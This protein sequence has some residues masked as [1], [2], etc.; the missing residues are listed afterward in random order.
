MSYIQTKIPTI[1][2]WQIRSI[3]SSSRLLLASAVLVILSSGCSVSASIAEREVGSDEKV[4]ATTEEKIRSVNV[5]FYD[6]NYFARKHGVE[7]W[8]S[9]A[10]GHLFDQ[11]KDLG[12]NRVF[13]RVSIM[14]LEAYPSKVR[15]TFPGPGGGVEPL[16]LLEGQQKLAD[17]LAEGFNPLEAA[18]EHGKRTGI[19]VYAWATLYDE[20]GHVENGNF[21]SQF[22]L[23]N[24]QYQWTSR[25]GERYFK[26]VLSYNFPEVRA[27]RMDE[28]REILSF[29]PD[30]VY[31][32]TRTHAFYLNEDSGDDFGYEAPVREAYLE[33]FGVDITK[34]EFDLEFWRVLR[35]EGIL[36]FMR[37]ASA[38]AKA[39]SAELV[40]G[41]K[42]ANLDNMGW[43]YG[44]AKSP[45]K[46]FVS[47]GLVDGIVFGH[48][49]TSPNKLPEIAQEFNA[50]SGSAGVDKLL[51]I[52]LYNYQKNALVSPE[53]LRLLLEALEV[54]DFDGGTFHQV[55]HLIDAKDLKKLETGIA[56]FFAQ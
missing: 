27:H 48:Y 3:G 42:S 9:P 12:I 39:S 55:D 19:G 7:K 22:V 51:W 13:W 26:G 31:L 49:L 46:Q 34:E 30:G 16:F 24:P 45:W 6:L 40:F 1:F 18:I 8:D 28:L 10:I 52:Q 11:L 23:K 38:A 32:C 21:A 36:S 5:D 4:D 14:G 54:N 47:E 50:V 33:R 53:S 20:Y 37:E 43:P 17:L 35:T 25:D 2:D 56:P 44:N 29:G 41:V 15:T